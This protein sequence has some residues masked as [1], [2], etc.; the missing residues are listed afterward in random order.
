MDEATGDKHAEVT[1]AVENAGNMPDAAIPQLY[2]HRI[3]GCMTARIK[4]LKNFARV[5]LAPGEKKQV[6][7]E[8]KEKD[9]RFYDY[10]IKHVSNA[11]AYDLYLSD[12][13]ILHNATKIIF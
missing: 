8:L 7:L 10:A 11:K 9:F 3:G 1:F 6:T 12:Q 2:I 5:E 4:E 13:G